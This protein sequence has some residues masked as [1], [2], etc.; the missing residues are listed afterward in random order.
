[1]SQT[2]IKYLPLF[3]L[4]FSMSAMTQASDLKKEQRWA[5]QIV[6]AVMVGEP[7]WLNDNKSRF[8]SLYTENNSEKELWKLLDVLWGW[9]MV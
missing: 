3:F 1:M 2:S 5:D 6:D 9:E 8:L 4:L 7:L